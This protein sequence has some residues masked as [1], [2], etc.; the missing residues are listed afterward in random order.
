[1]V[2]GAATDHATQALLQAELVL[3][4]VITNQ[5]YWVGFTSE[6]LITPSRLAVA[7]SIRSLGN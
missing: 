1:M 5:R 2:A 6:S 3:A 7:S 4:E